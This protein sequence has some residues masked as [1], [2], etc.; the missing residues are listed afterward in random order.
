MLQNYHDSIPAL[1]HFLTNSILNSFKRASLVLWRKNFIFWPFS[2][3]LG[4]GTLPPYILLAFF[5]KIAL[6]M[7]PRDFDPFLVESLLDPPARC[8]LWTPN[9]ETPLRFGACMLECLLGYK[10]PIKGNCTNSE[11]WGV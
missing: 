11:R 7:R 1:T 6:G 4:E 9:I 10:L 3:N 5:A 2:G 8:L